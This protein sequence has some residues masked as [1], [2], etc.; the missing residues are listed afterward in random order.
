[1]V[2]SALL[3]GEAVR[4]ARANG[5]RGGGAFKVGVVDAVSLLAG[6]DE[7]IGLGEATLDGQRNEGC[8]GGRVAD[9]DCGGYNKPN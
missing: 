9:G 7:R 6:A 1:M 5:D 3:E 2:R 8:A 4:G